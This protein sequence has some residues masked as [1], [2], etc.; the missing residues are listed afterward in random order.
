[1]TL[2]NFFV[3]CDILEDDDST[4]SFQEFMELFQDILEDKW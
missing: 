1:M 3:M 4:P 2:E